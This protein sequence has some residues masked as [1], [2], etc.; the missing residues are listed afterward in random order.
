MKYWESN[1]KFSVVFTTCNADDVLQV[2][3]SLF[4]VIFKYSSY[5]SQAHNLHVVYSHPLMSLLSDF[6][7]SPL[8]VCLPIYKIRVFNQIVSKDL[9]SLIFWPLFLWSQ[10][11]PLGRNGHLPHYPFSPF[12]L[13][14][15][16]WSFSW[17]YA[18]PTRLF[19]ASLTTGHDRVTNLRQGCVDRND[20][21]NFWVMTL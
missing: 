2:A 16:L 17:A 7:Q 21:C 3:V 19:P 6:G 8:W 9:F 5:H 18:W 20:V 14:T 11:P 1:S 12:S 15:E 4:F 13:V 10:E